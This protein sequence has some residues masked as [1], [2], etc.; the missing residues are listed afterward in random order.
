VIR[1]I[2]HM[3][4]AIALPADQLDE[5]RAI[6]RDEAT[7]V[8]VDGA[9]VVDRAG[10]LGRFSD[11]FRGP[12]SDGPPNWMALADAIWAALNQMDATRVLV[13]LTH[14]DELAARSMG[15]L[16]S[17]VLLFTDLDRQ[18]STAG[19]GFRQPARLSLVLLGDGTAFAAD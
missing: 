13:V 17:L 9:G 4:V 8:V 7:V 3:G 6:D 18:V 14:A 1:P 11:A 12:P 5:L 19:S 16:L 2:E 10:L 15:E